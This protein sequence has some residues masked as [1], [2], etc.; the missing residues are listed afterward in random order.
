MLQERSGSSVPPILNRMETRE[1]PPTYFRLSKF[2]RGFQN[3]VDAY[4]VANYREI[5][6]APYAIIT[7]PFL[8]AVMFGDFG[9]GVIMT[10]FSGWMVL[11]E[12]PLIA[13][14]SNSEVKSLWNQYFTQSLTTAF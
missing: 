5:N 12:K 8:F 1:T 3:L 2:T 7:F 6:P 13:K 14:K 11:N 10:L 4:G 9:H